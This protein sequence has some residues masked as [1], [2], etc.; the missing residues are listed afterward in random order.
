MYPENNL[1]DCIDNKELFTDQ[2]MTLIDGNRVFREETA[3]GAP[4]IP[5]LDL[6][7]VVEYLMLHLMTRWA[8]N[9]NL[10]TLK[11]LTTQVHSKIEAE[12]NAS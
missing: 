2:L 6:V 9:K 11:D 8:V 4:L 12:T 7:S 5:Q 1:L 3:A 10:L